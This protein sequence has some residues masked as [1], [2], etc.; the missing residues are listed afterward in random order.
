M[1]NKTR[2][3]GLYFDDTLDMFND[4]N[5]G[6][7]LSKLFKLTQR[8]KIAKLFTKIFLDIRFFSFLPRHLSQCF[9]CLK[10]FALG[11]RKIISTLRR[12]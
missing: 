6:K 3:T 11:L 12:R 5:K 4:E 10:L 8:I 1:N 7:L 2:Y 9:L